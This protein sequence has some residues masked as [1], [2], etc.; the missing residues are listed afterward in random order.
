MVCGAGK[1]VSSGARRVA[2]SEY[3]Q[4]IAVM[5]QQQRWAALAT[6]DEAGLPAASMV[7]Y[8]TDTA[9]GC[10]YLHLSALAA[11]TRELLQ[12][13]A[14]ALVISEC[15]AGSGDPQQLARLSLR[16]VCEPIVRDATGYAEARQCYLRRLPDAERLFGF[17]DFMLLRFEI[18]A[19]R[20]VG[21]FGQAHSYRG[22]EICALLREG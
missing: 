22:E 11:H 3:R 2:K 1:Q 10:L 6:V 21:G 4:Q 14:A 19:A 16:G 18:T 9:Q 5:L 12:Q 20:F 17:G 8:A 7:A 15:D 13:P